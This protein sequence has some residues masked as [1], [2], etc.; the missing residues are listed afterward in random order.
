MALTKVNVFLPLRAGSER[1][2]SKNTRLFAGIHGGLCKIKLQQLLACER[3]AHIF[4][5]T[6]DNFVNDIV[7]SFNSKKISLIDRPLHL[8]TSDASTDDLIKYAGN[9]MPEG[10][11]LWTHATSPFVTA[12]VYDNIIDTYFNCLAQFDSLMT[13]TKVQK[14]LWSDMGPMNYDSSLEKWPRT[15]T[16]KPLWEVNSACFIAPRSIYKSLNDRIG[17]NPKLLPLEEII[18]YDIDWEL[19][20]QVAELL[21]EMQ[22]VKTK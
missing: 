22:T 8:A 2:K 3:V 18:S 12:S 17:S 5:S 1:V 15:Q 11:I 13:V 19:N 16:L 4:V 9:V 14:F 10:D 20:F 21:Y 6:D 7:R